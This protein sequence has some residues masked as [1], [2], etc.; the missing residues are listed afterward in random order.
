MVLRARSRANPPL[1]GFSGTRPQDRAGIWL[2]ASGRPIV[3][4]LSP[5]PRHSTAARACAPGSTL[6]GLAAHGCTRYAT[7]CVLRAD[8]MP[9]VGGVLQPVGTQYHHHSPAPT[10]VHLGGAARARLITCQTEAL[11][12]QPRPCPA[13]HSICGRPWRRIAVQPAL[14]PLANQID[15]D[16]FALSSGRVLGRWGCSRF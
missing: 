9:S 13:S 11:F 7:A 16:D 14:A 5:P 15:P 4:I 3:D 2:N 10:L 1:T 12:I 8:C 6:Q